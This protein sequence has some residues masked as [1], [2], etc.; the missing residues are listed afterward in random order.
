MFVIYRRRVR[1]TT[2]E[3]KY[4]NK[5]NQN[6][7][8]IDKDGRKEKKKKYIYMSLVLVLCTTSRGKKRYM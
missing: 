8:K 1:I 3:R 6:N 7:G 5:I 2:L 4:L